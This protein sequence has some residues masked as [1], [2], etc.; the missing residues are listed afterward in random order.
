MNYLPVVGVT[1]EEIGDIATV[2]KTYST[3]AATSE[4]FIVFEDIL[5]TIVNNDA[6]DEK[7]VA[8]GVQ[9]ILDSIRN[10]KHNFT[11]D[12]CR[13]ISVEKE[14]DSFEQL[15]EALSSRIN[16]INS[17]IDSIYNVLVYLKDHPYYDVIDGKVIA[18]N[19]REVVVNIGYSSIGNRIYI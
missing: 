10:S 12:I 3:L 14:I 9:P 13:D 5:S 19:D 8:K 11:N 18:I 7:Y 6:M 17:Y 16:E 1:L 4:S 2:A 15:F